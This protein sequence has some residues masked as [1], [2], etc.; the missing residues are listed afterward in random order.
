MNG[1]TDNKNLQGIILVK[2]FLIDEKDKLFLNEKKVAETSC[3]F[4][5]NAVTKLW[6]NRDDD[7]FNVKPQLST[8][9]V[10][11]ATQTLGNVS[12]VKLIRDNITLSDMFQ[13]QSVSLDSI[14]KEITNLYSAKN[15]AF[16][17]NQLVV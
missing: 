5:E 10:N 11:I 6:I 8:N 16:K 1:I 7:K 12:S 4:F 2:P 3:N 13:F 9:P 15:G 17:K 14:L